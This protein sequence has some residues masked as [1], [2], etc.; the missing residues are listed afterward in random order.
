[1]STGLTVYVKVIKTLTEQ[2]PTDAIYSFETGNHCLWAQRYLPM[3]TFP[4][5]LSTRSGTMSYIYHQV[6][7][8]HMITDPDELTISVLSSL[9]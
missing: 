7:L 3:H 1:M 4:S 5:P 9:S 6:L 2:L 8:L